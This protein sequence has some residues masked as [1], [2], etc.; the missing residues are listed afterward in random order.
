MSSK[1]IKALRA[2]AARA[3][4][5]DLVVEWQ[6]VAIDNLDTRRG[7]WLRRLVPQ[8]ELS[9]GFLLICAL[10]ALPLAGGRAAI[11]A[12]SLV[13]AVGL[14]LLPG[15]LLMSR[16]GATRLVCNARGAELQ[17]P[18]K[19]AIR[20]VVE[21]LL[22]TLLNGVAAALL[23]SL[24]RSVGGHGRLASL[25]QIAGTILAAWGA[26]QVLPVLP[27]Q[28]GSLLALRLPPRVRLALC[29]ASLALV[30][31]GGFL[32]IVAT[33]RPSLM[34]VVVASSACALGWWREILGQ[35]LEDSAGAP[36]LVE[37]VERALQRGE[38]GEAIRL[39]RETMVRARSR[40]VRTRLCLA[41]AWGAIAEADVFLAHAALT[42]L[43]PERLS[44]HLVAAYLRSC[45][46]F[47]EAETLLMR[48]R[49]LGI[50]TRETTKL[51][52]ELL[53]VRGAAKEAGFLA[54]EDAALLDGADWAALRVVGFVPAQV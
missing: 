21:L 17:A 25:L 33:Q 26:A 11:A 5:T 18:G 48:A 20:A 52:L 50:R 14:Q 30:V 19:G 2:R 28:L 6:R 9:G 51:L 37:E 31:S 15:L 3:A 42:E 38:T 7:G 27:F 35:V 36:R 54:L 39:A 10:S 13:C 24:A 46:R 16:T 34:V 32:A 44:V 23:L 40:P 45:R 12:L 29:T 1:R 8:V 41:M 53:F 22:G 43:P 4:S 47:A 49:S